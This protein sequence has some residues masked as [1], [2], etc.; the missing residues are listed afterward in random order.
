M[1]GLDTQSRDRA[2]SVKLRAGVR[3]AM[4]EGPIGRASTRTRKGER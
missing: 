4:D 2:F 1:A 3:Q